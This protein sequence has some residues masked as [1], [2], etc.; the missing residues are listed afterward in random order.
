MQFFILVLLP[1]LIWLIEN[2]YITLIYALH[3]TATDVPNYLNHLY[4]P[5]IFLGKQIGI[6]IPFFIMFIFMISKFK[7]KFNLKDKKLLFFISHKFCAN[8]FNVFDFIIHGYK[9]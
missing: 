9:N 8:I 2:N 3:R 6:L 7:I 1:H 4:Y 5:L